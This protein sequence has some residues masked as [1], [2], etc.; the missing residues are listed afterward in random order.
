MKNISTIK[1]RIVQYLDYKGISKNRFYIQT[2]IGN[3]TL[4]KKGAI[5]S[6]S[7]EKIFKEFTDL[8]LIWLM[9]GHSEMIIDPTTK[10]K[11]YEDFVQ[12]K[13]NIPLNEDAPIVKE[14]N[15][16]YKEKY[17]ATLERLN[18]CLETKDKM[19]SDYKQTRIDVTP[20]N[21]PKLNV[22]E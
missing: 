11:H 18:E 16:D 21:T 14:T 4:D 10:D 20:S 13:H 3:G 22:N 17:Y 8:N 1:E 2:G 7:I 9:T 15:V 5:S 6:D 19:R 12:G